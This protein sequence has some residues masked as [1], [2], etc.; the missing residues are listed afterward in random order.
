MAWTTP[1]TWAS[2]DLVA[3]SGGLDL[4]PDLKTN[5]NVLKTPAWGTDTTV[6]DSISSV[7]PTAISGLSVTITTTG[8]YVA[9]IFCASFYTSV[10][11]NPTNWQ[12]RMDGTQFGSTIQIYSTG[13]TKYTPI[14]IY[15]ITDTPPSAGSHTFTIYW[16]YSGDT[17]TLA[18]NTAH[19]FAMETL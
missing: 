15:A 18:T 11:A 4:N 8:G 2:G 6:S 3:A 19:L 17:I 14:C 1:V 12:T 7:T 16:S 9:V 10:A 13:A 5:M